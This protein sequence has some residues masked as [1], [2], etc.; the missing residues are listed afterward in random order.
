[1]WFGGVVVGLGEVAKRFEA[2]VQLHGPAGCAFGT[3]SSL[4]ERRCRAAP[5]RLAPAPPAVVVV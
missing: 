1:L 4:C 2:V 5:A 3:A